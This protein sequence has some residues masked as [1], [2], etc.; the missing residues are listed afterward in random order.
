MF[1]KKKKA[2]P[3]KVKVDRKELVCHHCQGDRF[4]AMKGQLNT[5]TAS[6][7]DLDWFNPEAECYVC[8]G[9]GY[10]HWFLKEG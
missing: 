1:N 6:L 5:K 9:C 2:P 7:L 4:H 10:V 8:A 3:E